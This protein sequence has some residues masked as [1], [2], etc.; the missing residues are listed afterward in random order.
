MASAAPKWHTKLT[1]SGCFNEVHDAPKLGQIKP[2]YL[3]VF[4][5]SCRRTTL[6]EVC[7][8]INPTGIEAPSTVPLFGMPGGAVLKLLLPYHFSPSPV[9]SPPAF[10]FYIEPSV[11][12]PA[13]CE[14]PNDPMGPVM[15]VGS[16]GLS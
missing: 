2:S 7:G 12:Q 11:D 14:P 13:L 9:S 8:I 6:Y 10:T 15:G 16:Y 5:C 1:P 3:N 4:K